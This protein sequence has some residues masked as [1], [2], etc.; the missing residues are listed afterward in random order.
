[1]F[2]LPAGIPMTIDITDMIAMRDITTTIDTT[3][4]RDIVDIIITRDT[5][6]D[7]MDIIPVRIIIPTEW[8]IH[9]LIRK[10]F[11]LVIFLYIHITC[12]IV[13]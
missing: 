2:P 1:M 12:F 9:I 4:I 10:V 13:S 8:T 3:D 5:I 11:S 7:T 6:M